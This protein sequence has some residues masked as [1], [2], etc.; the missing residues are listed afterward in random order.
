MGQRWHR[1][2]MLPSGKGQ[3][4][5]HVL[6]GNN[7]RVLSLAKE[8]QQRLANCK[9]LVSPPD[10]WLHMTILNVGLADQINASQREVMISEAGRLLA[11]VRPVTVTLSRVLYHPEAIVVAAEPVEVLTPLL[12]ATRAATRAAIGREGTTE[13]EPWTPHVTVAYSDAVQPAAPII[14]AMGREL[15]PCD[16]AIRTVCLVNQDGPENR[17]DWHPIAQVPLGHSS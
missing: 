8:S 12:E 7:S 11:E 6:L 1:K 5:W 2:P 3:L 17:W 10:R 15:P 13:H 4:Y 16:V 14:A 9:G